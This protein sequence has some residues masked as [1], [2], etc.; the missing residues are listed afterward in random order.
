MIPALSVSKPSAATI[1]STSELGFV[2]C[3]RLLL[4]HDFVKVQIAATSENGKDAPEAFEGD[5]PP[6]LGPE[7]KVPGFWR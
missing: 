1:Q 4:A 7:S 2:G 6:T 3:R 5:I